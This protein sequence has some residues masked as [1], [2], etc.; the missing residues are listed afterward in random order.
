[1]T[2]LVL[3]DTKKFGGLKKLLYLLKIYVMPIDPI[4]AVVAGSGLVQGLSS[5]FGQRS[6]NRTNIQLA[7]EQRQ[8]DLDMWNR[9]NEY[10]NP[11]NQMLRLSAA[12]L[13]PNLVYGSG[14]VSGNVTGSSPKASLAHVDNVMSGFRPMDYLMSTI[15]AYQTLKKNEAEVD[16]IQANK[17]LAERRAQTETV[18]SLL[19]TTLVNLNN[20]RVP[21]T[22]SQKLLS[23]VNIE[24]GGKKIALADVS[25]KI[26]EARLPILYNEGKISGVK[27]SFADRLTQT[28]LENLRLLTQLRRQQGSLNEARLGGI[29]L[30]NAIKGLNLQ[31]ETELKKFN[32]TSKDPALSRFILSLPRVIKNTFKGYD[33]TGVI[34]H[35]KNGKYAGSSW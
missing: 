14:S 34:N 19:K 27:A 25:R 6:A 1:M 12:G 16:L 24:L 9:Q 3:I 2:I 32:A 15:G 23:D 10:N 4:T 35:Y 21:L 33:N 20:E 7:R 26:G 31:F 13:N 11:K 17:E 30:D 5:I 22:R 28:E 18:N 8:W 29:N